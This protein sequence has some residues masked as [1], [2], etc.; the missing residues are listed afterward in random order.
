M[1]WIH[2]ALEDRDEQ[3]T[4]L[5]TVTKFQVPRMRGISW[6]AKELSASQELC[7]TQLHKTVVRPTAPCAS[8]ELL[9]CSVL[10][11]FL[12][13]LLPFTLVTPSLQIP[14]FYS[15]PPTPPQLSLLPPFVLHQ[16]HYIIITLMIITPSIFNFMFC[17][18]FSPLALWTK[19]FQLVLSCNSSL[20][21]CSSQLSHSLTVLHTTQ[22]GEG[23]TQ[24]TCY[25]TP[26]DWF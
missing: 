8:Y 15:P 23:K 3:G 24:Q 7:S 6:L 5:Y 21:Q 4:L 9:I 19:T 1:N 13:C 18:T 2:L 16:Y 12:L 10:G 14:A 20:F 25:V 11:L 26:L 22:D 17:F